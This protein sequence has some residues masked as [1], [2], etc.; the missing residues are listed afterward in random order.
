VAFD[1]AVQV[2]S[3]MSQVAVEA[4]D[5][6][7]NLTRV[8]F[9]SNLARPALAEKAPGRRAA[10]VVGVSEYRSPRDGL[11][12]LRFAA[13]DARAVYELLVDPAFGGFATQDVEMLLDHQ[14]TVPAV[15]DALARLA[16]R[17]GPED[18][19]FV[20]VNAHG[21]P[22]P[23][24]KAAS[25]PFYFLLHDTRLSDL[26]RTG[27]RM[28]TIAEVLNQ[29]RFRAGRKIIFIDACHSGGVSSDLVEAASRG[30]DQAARSLARQQGVALLT[31]SSVDE[32]SLELVR[33][34]SGNGVF[35]LAL[36]EALRGAADEN[37]DNLITAGEL[38]SAVSTCVRRA[39]A[40]RQNP[41]ALYDGADGLLMARVPGGAAPGPP[42]GG[43]S[44]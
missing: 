18:L 36:L 37:R 34:R 29:S 5:Q 1:E 22:D 33:G 25:P 12:N 14:A 17:L 20:Y 21:A 16:G 6:A 43:C 41:Q 27:Y 15:R 11:G 28:D 30:L 10:L 44:P 35:T 9:R 8:L 24:E 19:L 39:T 23:Y 13:S 31:S 40:G 38:F 2:P 4:R 32:T 3:D 7:G 42:Q 26:P